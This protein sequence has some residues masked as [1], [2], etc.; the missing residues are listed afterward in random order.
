VSF[1]RRSFVVR[2][3]PL[4]L[5]A[6]A[7]GCGPS[8]VTL[9]TPPMQAE[10]A[11][12]VMTYQMPTA[13]LDTTKIDQVFSDAQTRLAELHLDWLPD[14]LSDALT[15]LQSRLAAA[16]LSSDPASMPD[17]RKGQLTAVATVTRICAGWSD[18]P[19]P[20]D[21]AA[22][23]SIEVTAIVDTGRI[24]PEVWGT[25]TNCLA[26]FP[27]A[28]STSNDAVVSDTSTDHSMVVNATL[29]GTL[30]LYLLG[31]LPVNPADAQMLV[32]FSGSIGV[33]DQV[34][35]ASF[36]FQISKSQVQFRVPVASG[37]DAIVTV[38]TTLG[39]Q[40]ANAG[41]SCDLTTLTCQQTS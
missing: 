41:F 31:P 22:N 11:A 5:A 15:R 1:R 12:L 21:A 26:R 30:I 23:G 32:I 27:P 40:G 29:N 33:G 3:G 2:G 13:T 7:L 14:L 4:T 17:T 34:G 38:G 39:I 8:T 10:T 37:G 18:P 20:P 28:G 9:P 25:A 16:G 6:A 24:N 35:S 36:D 19:G